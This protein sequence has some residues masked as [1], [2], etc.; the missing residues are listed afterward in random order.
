MICSI[1][2]CGGGEGLGEGEVCTDGAH[3]MRDLGPEISWAPCG[4]TVVHSG[5]STLRV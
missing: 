2:S 4:C 3:E 5:L 1:R